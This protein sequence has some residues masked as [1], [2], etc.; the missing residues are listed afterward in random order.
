M[1]SNLGKLEPVEVTKD[2][3]SLFRSVARVIFQDETFWLILKVGS[4]AFGIAQEELLIEKV[5]YCFNVF[6]LLD[7]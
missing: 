2:E 6:T 3:R 7:L 5:C 1:P 4:I